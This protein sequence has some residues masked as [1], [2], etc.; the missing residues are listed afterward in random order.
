ME[1]LDFILTSNALYDDLIDI[2]KGYLT[3]DLSIYESG[4]IETVN[5]QIP[6]LHPM[7]HSYIIRNIPDVRCKNW[8]YLKEY[9]LMLHKL[10]AHWGSRAI[11]CQHLTLNIAVDLRKDQLNDR[12]FLEEV[13]QGLGSYTINQYGK[14]YHGLNLKLVFSG[15]VY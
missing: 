10:K 9:F 15:L 13:L 6:D 5:E 14:Y 4:F 7:R 1:T 8:R 11:R 3:P 2:I 12:R